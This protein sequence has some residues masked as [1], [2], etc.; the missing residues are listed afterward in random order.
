[1]SN[2]RSIFHFVEID[3][4]ETAKQ[5]FVIIIT[6]YSIESTW[7]CRFQVRIYCLV[8]GTQLSISLNS[9]LIDTHRSYVYL[10]NEILRKCCNQKPMLW[11]SV[12]LYSVQQPY[13]CAIQEVKSAT[14]SFVQREILS[15]DFLRPYVL[16]IVS[17]LLCGV[18]YA[19]RDKVV[20]I[21]TFHIQTRRFQQST[22][23]KFIVYLEFIVRDEEERWRE[24]ERNLA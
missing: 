15:I 24:L 7:M 5:A 16:C 2:F 21:S 1:M 19:V 22:I 3:E 9:R 17:L 14:H 8:S 23:F 6:F 13:P 4:I 10:I 20:G 11:C 12:V 18:D